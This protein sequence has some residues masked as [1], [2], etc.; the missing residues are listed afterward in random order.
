MI[1]SPPILFLLV[2]LNFVLANADGVVPQLLSE[3]EASE[4]IERRE[5]AKEARYQALKRE[6]SSAQVVES[7]EVRREGRPMTVNMIEPLVLEKPVPADTGTADKRPGLT[8][9]EWAAYVESRQALVHEQISLGANVYGD[10]YSEITWRD[11]ETRQEFTVWTNVSLNYL[12]PI[13]TIRTE[14]FDYTY[15]GFVTPYTRE[16]EQARIDFAAERGFEIES[17]WKEPPVG[18]S[19]DRYEYAVVAEGADVPEKLHRQLEAVLGHYVEHKE[20]LEIGH[21]NAETLRAAREKYLRENPPR[22]RET[23][24]N[25]WRIEE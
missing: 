13:S 1:K 2:A 3:E 18:F 21:K 24:I 9:E 22:P 25:F 17:R 4:I 14:G 5:A 20:E 23:V 11:T 10:E 8:P 7:K 19:E 6:M 12:R 15:F 16:G